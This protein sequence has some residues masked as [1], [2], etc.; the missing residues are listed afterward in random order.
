MKAF[1]A[2]FSALIVSF[3]ALTACALAGTS[4]DGT[5]SV[6]IVGQPTLA[7]EQIISAPCVEQPTAACAN[8]R[9][10]RKYNEEV[11]QSESCR[12]RLFGGH[13]VRKST[14][15]VYRPVRR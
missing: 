8:G 7:D 10:A 12:N 2:C 5:Q 3:V 6:L 1:T 4:A 11:E 9:C 13:V 14:R 15:T